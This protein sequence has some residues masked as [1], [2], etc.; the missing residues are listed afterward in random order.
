MLKP[1]KT[2]NFQKFFRLHSFISMLSEK[3]DFPA[4]RLLR[5]ENLEFIL[6]FFYSV[7]RNSKEEIDTIKQL[8]IEKELEN[9]IVSFNKK[10]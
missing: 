9:F 5:S 2:V 4:L 10:I 3:L 1:K 6:G 8:K 7:F